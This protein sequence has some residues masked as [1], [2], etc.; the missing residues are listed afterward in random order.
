MGVSR[1][2]NYTSYLDGSPVSSGAFGLGRLNATGEFLIGNGNG[3]SSG[4]KGALDEVRVYS[5]AL[6]SQEISRLHSARYALPCA[7]SMKVDYSG[8]SQPAPRAYYNANLTLRTLDP[9]TLLSLPF[10]INSSAPGSSV[11]DYSAS[12]LNCTLA[13]GEFISNGK[14]GNAYGFSS[15]GDGVSVNSSVISGSTDFTISLWVKPNSTSGTTYLAGN[16]G[17]GNPNGVSLELAGGYPVLSIGPSSMTGAISAQAGSWTHIVAGRENGVGMIYVNS[18]NAST[19]ALS[20]PVGNGTFAIGNSPDF[21]EP[22]E[23]AMDEVRAYSRFIGAQ[24]IT[25]LYLDL[26][27]TYSGPL[28][29]APP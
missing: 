29:A 7:I 20:G 8:F 26:G 13:G 2:G 15:P 6:S 22:F 5:R 10:E 27:K 24:E 12:L 11:Q 9:S 1:A 16:L 28:P 23:G 17:A 3:T 14:F 19:G 21:S 4:F 18:L 25:A